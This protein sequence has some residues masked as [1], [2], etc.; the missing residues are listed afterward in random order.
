MNVHRSGWRFEE[1]NKNLVGDILAKQVGTP[2]TIFEQIPLLHYVC[3]LEIISAIFGKRQV[4]A[5]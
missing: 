1:A 3:Y 5:L 2:I 4:F